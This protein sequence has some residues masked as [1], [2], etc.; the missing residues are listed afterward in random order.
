MAGTRRGP[1]GGKSS[2][3]VAKARPALEEANGEG[4]PALEEAN[5][6]GHPELEGKTAK[7]SPKKPKRQPALGKEEAPTAGPLGTRPG[8]L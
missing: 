4:Q 8:R 6:E 2:K 1:R 3:K 5:G 7:A